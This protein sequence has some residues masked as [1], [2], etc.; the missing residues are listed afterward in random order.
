MTIRLFVLLL[1]LTFS[2][3][4][5]VEVKAQT[6]F[7][8]QT[9]KAPAFSI[10]TVNDLR[11]V[12]RGIRP[13]RSTA[14]AKPTLAPAPFA[15]VVGKMPT[16]A[17]ITGTVAN[18]YASAQGVVLSILNPAYGENSQL[19]VS[20]VSWG[21]MLK[22]SLQANDPNA[23]VACFLHFDLPEARLAEVHFDGLPSGLHTY[24]L[25]IG[26]DAPKENFV[27]YR[28]SDGQTLL[29]GPQLGF[30]P[31]TNEVRGA[32]I[33]DQKYIIFVINVTKPAKPP[34]VYHFHHVQLAC[35]D[36]Q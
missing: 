33:T 27:V 11:T 26:T 24:A 4:F 14:G 10:S 18:P 30:D 21:P 29:T 23:S 6:Q 28:G 3:A 36:C 32:V 17:T 31:K 1:V 9:V 13:V 2:F 34:Y 15:P 12:M 7:Q 20:G 22:K 5:Q 25:S 35:L 8:P 16:T 19:Y